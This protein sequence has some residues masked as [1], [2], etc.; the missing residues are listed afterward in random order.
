MHKANIRRKQQVSGSRF[1][2]LSAL[3][4]DLLPLGVDLLVVDLSRRL[5]L[6]T[7][8]MLFGGLDTDS[9]RTSAADLLLG[10]FPGSATIIDFISG[11]WKSVI[12]RS[13]ILE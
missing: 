6:L 5:A 12:A 2:S 10:F 4:D 3:L 1:P 9:R 8:R 7:F 13:C 11:G